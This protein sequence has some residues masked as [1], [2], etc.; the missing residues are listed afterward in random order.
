MC[1]ARHCPSCSKALPD[2]G[3]SC[4]FCGAA[5]EGSQSDLSLIFGQLIEEFTRGIR[6]GKTPDVESYERRYPRLAARIRELF[7]TLIA[8]ESAAAARAEGSPASEIPTVEPP[9]RSS[10]SSTSPAQ[11][12]FISGTIISGRYR[13]VG[14]LGRGGMGEVYRAE[15]LQLG[16]QVALKFLSRNLALDEAALARFHQEV[17]LARQISHPNVCKVF[18]VGKDNACR[19]LSMEYIDGEDLASLLRRIGRLPRDKAV[20]IARQLCAGLTAAHE[21]SVLHRDLKPANIMIDG[22]G[23]VRITDFGL[24]AL[25]G[26]T[27]SEM[28]AGTPAYMAPE[29]LIQRECTPKSDIYALGLVLYEIFTGYKVFHAESLADLERL[30][31]Q[32]SPVPP[33][34]LVRDVDRKV[35]HWIMRCLEKDPHLRPSALEIAAAMPGGDPLAVA[36]EAGVTPSPEMVA[37][38]PRERSF[39]PLTAFICLSACL[40][41]L[42]LIVLL[43]GKGLLHR[44][45]PLEMRPEVLADRAHSLAQSLGY[46]SPPVDVEYGFLRNDD[47]LDY[48]VRND[49]SPDRWNRLAASQPPALYFWYRQSPGYLVP[50]S[51]GKVTLEDPPLVFPGMVNVSLDTVGRLS[52]F[53]A[54]PVETGL[55]G[56]RSPSPWK[57]MFDAAGLDMAAFKPVPSQW[58][59][60]ETSDECAAWQGSIGTQPPVAIR[61]EAAAHN[62]SPVFFKIVYPWSAPPDAGVYTPSEGRAGYQHGAQNRAFYA[63]SFLVFLAAGLTNVLLVRHNLRLGRGDRRGAFRLA[64]YIFGAQLLAWLLQT[65]HV[66]SIAEIDLFYTALAWALFYSG[67]SWLLYIALEPYIRRY[68]PYRIISWSRLL[69][70]G[71]RDPLVGRDLLLGAFLG[72]ASTLVGAYIYLALKMFGF[73]PDKPPSLALGALRGGARGVA[74]QI[75]AMQKE[76]IGDPLYVL[77]VLLLLFV[78]LHKEW[79]ACI[80]AWM[81]FTFGAAKLFEVQQVTSWLVVGVVVGAYILVLAR[82]GLLAAMVFQFYNFLL[83]NCPITSDLFTWYAGG[84]VLALLVAAGVA[85][86]GFYISLAGQSLLNIRILKALG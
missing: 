66:R 71:L 48:I 33:S 82:F 5:L 65:H 52:E 39:R 35:E 29:Q 23:R 54:V 16:Q 8:L 75:I 10:D 31:R 85:L 53:R 84:T 21:N 69:A 18:D 56:M 7:P 12:R 32:T 41:C 22:R 27:G 80:S 62:R 28:H 3:S 19:F 79:L 81:M 1:A 42:L 34:R 45:V 60:A 17:R 58:T 44:S 40:G 15:D 77:V 63:F 49:P 72:T 78:I 46:S 4:P 20:D 14:L 57:A 6:E 38:S 59:V 47:Y 70:G 24:A 25:A 73:P 43:S 67:V 9:S 37:A 36:L 11:S 68:W 51:Q 76:V 2:E 83:L 26:E 86:Y 30:H 64:L 50:Y 61:V 74:G 55:S 13:I